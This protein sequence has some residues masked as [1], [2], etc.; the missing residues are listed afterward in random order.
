VP[1]TTDVSVALVARVVVPEAD[2][3]S[4]SV[5]VCWPL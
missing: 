3:V 5:L 4:A 1:P 2:S